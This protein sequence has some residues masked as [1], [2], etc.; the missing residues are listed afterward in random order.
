MFVLIEHTISDSAGEIILARLNLC[1]GSNVE[2][3]IPEASVKNVLI[4]FSSNFFNVPYHK[5][6]SHGTMRFKL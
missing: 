4:G 3:S 1:D 6:V 2:V 5:I